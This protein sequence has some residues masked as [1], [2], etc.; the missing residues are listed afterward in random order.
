[1]KLNC[2]RIKVEDHAKLDTN[3]MILCG[4]WGTLQVQPGIRCQSVSAWRF[5]T[6]LYLEYLWDVLEWGLCQSSDHVGSLGKNCWWCLATDSEWSMARN[7]I[8]H[9]WEQLLWIYQAP[10]LNWPFK[11]FS[12]AS[13]KRLANSRIHFKG[14]ARRH[15]LVFSSHSWSLGNCSFYKTEYKFSMAAVAHQ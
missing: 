12:Y 8:L 15:Q 14:T 13:T 6:W 2:I 7:V 5:F 10:T 4:L 3:I 1:M 9:G 11:P